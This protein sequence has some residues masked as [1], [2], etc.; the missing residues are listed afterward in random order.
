MMVGFEGL[1]VEWVVIGRVVCRLR[2]MP[3]LG[4]TSTLFFEPRMA[5]SMPARFLRAHLQLKNLRP[6]A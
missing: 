3:A 1:V 5:H 2:A 4:V 6:S